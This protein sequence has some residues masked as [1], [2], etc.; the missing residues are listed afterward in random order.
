MF[1]LHSLGCAMPHAVSKPFW[2]SPL[3][4]PLNDASAWNRIVQLF[5]RR[6]SLTECRASVRAVVHEC[7]DVI[8]LHLHPNRRFKGFRAGQH[9]ALTLPV[10]GVRQSRTFSLSQ[11]PADDGSLRLTIKI[12]AEGEVSKAAAMLE[13]GD[14]VVLSQASGDFV[15][16][17]PQRAVLLL[18]AGSGITPIMA[19]LQDWSRHADA[20]DAV[21]LHCCRNPDDFIFSR[22]LQTLVSCY[23]R[24]RVIPVF[25]AEHGRLDAHGLQR[26]VPDY[27]ERDAL[28]CGPPEFMAWIA[29]FYAQQGL[30]AQLR[31]E[32]FQPRVTA[33]QPDAERFSAYHADGR[34]AFT[35]Q[36]GQS[37]LEAA[38]ADGLK[39][40]HGC[41]RGICMTCQCRKLAGVVHNQ[42]TDTVSGAGE[43]WIRLCVSTPIS[44]LHLEL[45]S[46]G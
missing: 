15:H 2:A 35:A 5:N 29:D 13:R 39:P 11:A 26:R 36:R 10:G 9:L 44:D 32:H 30:S 22:E 6:W 34:A 45:A 40:V 16:A 19:M 24:L 27:A 3:W 33:V 28:L 37:L 42:L 7:P 17:Q 1:T 21:L 41:R 43:E 12:K 14:V 23:P 38:E 25:S 31:Q 4:Q 46:H 18:S 20:P 8:S